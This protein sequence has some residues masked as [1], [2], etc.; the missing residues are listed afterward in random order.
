MAYTSPKYTYVS[1][2]PAFQR[3]QDDLS[4]S[5]VAGKERART[6]EE[7]RLKEL[8][9]N[10]K[11]N[12]D[13]LRFGRAQNM[14]F[15]KKWWEKNQYD[16]PN[17]E[18]VTKKFFSGTGKEYAD[19]AMKINSGDCESDNCETEM[20]ELQVLEG[21]PEATA[22]FIGDLNSEFSKIGGRDYDKNQ[23]SDYTL[24]SKIF[25]GEPGFT[26]KDGYKV[27]M[28]R[29]DDGTIE[30]VFEGPGFKDGK[31]SINNNTLGSTLDAGGELIHTVL[32]MTELE[33]ELLSDSGIFGEDMLD[34]QGKL[35]PTAMLSEDYLVMGPDGKPEYETIVSKDGMYQQNML[36]WDEDKFNNKLKLYLD[37]QLETMQEDP[38]D[39]IGLWNVRL[40]AG[41]KTYDEDLA[42]AALGLPDAEADVVKQAWGESKFSKLV[43]EP[44]SYDDLPLS[45]EKRTLFAAMYTSKIK[46][47]FKK[48]FM[49]QM[50]A[51][52]IDGQ[53]TYTQKALATLNTNT[54]TSFTNPGAGSW[55]TG[56]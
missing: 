31:L 4:A 15:N 43:Q 18:S 25:N 26:S 39:M 41:A 6:A 46:N 23:E 11:A 16:N 2:A 35:L 27:D 30:M 42:R 13:L 8:K 51:P 53:L 20:A 40:S 14:A 44:W 38:S 36:K 47:S 49:P 52:G 12:D 3:L 34:D 55:N 37:T 17:A 19:L 29:N 1:N 10:E 21:Y 45:D 5:V 50:A 32:N 9:E 56:G 28:L 33:N 54:N 22:D 24:A 48:R 7:E